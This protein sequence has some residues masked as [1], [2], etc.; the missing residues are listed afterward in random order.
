MGFLRSHLVYANGNM[1][2]KQKQTDNS[3][4]DVTEVQ[5]VLYVKVKA[6]L[7]IYCFHKGIRLTSWQVMERQIEN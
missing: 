3:A 5:E 7:F 2:G 6:K 1:N 4:P